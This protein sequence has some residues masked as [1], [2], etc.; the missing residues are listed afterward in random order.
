MDDYATINIYEQAICIDI[1][2]SVT[3]H[4]NAF[5]EKVDCSINLLSSNS[6]HDW[7]QC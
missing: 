4:N 1:P 7:S 6:I 3:D 2:I 5:G